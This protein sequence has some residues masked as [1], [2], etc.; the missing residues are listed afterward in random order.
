MVD[1]TRGAPQSLDLLTKALE[2]AE[3]LDDLDAQA[4]AL[5]GLITH[6]IFSAEHDK[7]WAAAERLLQ[8][9]DRIGDAALSRS[10]DRTDGQ[11]RWSWS[12]GRERRENFWKD[13]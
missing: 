7:A 2:T 3:A 10:A 8:V 4:R 6:H 1:A 13:S 12:A 9:A 5:M 11:L